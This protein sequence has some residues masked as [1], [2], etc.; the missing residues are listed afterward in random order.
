[1]I[2]FLGLLKNPLTK[3]IAEKT[4]GAIQH[5]LDKDKIIKKFNEK[6]TIFKYDFCIIDKI[7]KNTPN[8]KILHKAYLE[9]FKFE[10]R[11]HKKI[12]FIL[13]RYEEMFTMWQI[14]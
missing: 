14:I 5:K 8:N 4:F 7:F 2:Q 13:L 12:N 6:K 11:N 3:I 10:K 1:M 9:G